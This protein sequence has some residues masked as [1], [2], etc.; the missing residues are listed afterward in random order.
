M[1]YD[2]CLKCGTPKKNGDTECP[3]CGVIYEKVEKK[4]EEEKRNNV[5]IKCPICNEEFSKDH[6]VCPHC[7]KLPEFFNNDKNNKEEVNR[8]K[9]NNEEVKQKTIMEETKNASVSDVTNK[10][11]PEAITAVLIDKLLDF[12]RS[13]YSYDFFEKNENWLTK[14]GLFGLYVLALLGLILSIVFPL[15]HDLD[16]D[17]YFGFGIVWFFLCFIFHYTAW[18]FLPA[19]SHIIQT[20]PTK[21]S[22]KAFLDTL[23]L[24]AGIAGVV[25]I[26]SGL[27]L[28][29]EKSSIELFITGIFIFIICEYMLSLCLHPENLNIKLNEQ[30]SVGEEFLGLISFFMKS[31]IKLIPIVFGLGI[32]FGIINLLELLLVKS[33]F[34]EQ[35]VEMV[36]DIWT[37]FAIALLPVIGYLLFL[38]YYFVIDLAIA[39]L[40]IPPKLDRL[41]RLNQI[42]DK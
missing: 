17:T 22:T 30:I 23:A 10:I 33:N 12:L 9:I 32:V 39:I 27:L 19:L 42:S 16:F 6:G 36:S 35:Q 34:L 26:M 15:R 20:T 14:A 21:L 31:F 41:D 5:T 25:S 8:K 24:I 2:K 40:S 3:K 7:G 1:K 29:I 13:S 11:L 18:K 4:Y 37:L 28:W 38:V